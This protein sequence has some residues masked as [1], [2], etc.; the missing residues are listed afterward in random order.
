MSDFNV[1]ILADSISD[2]GNRIT[3]LQLH[4]WRPLLAEINTHRC[5]SRNA[6]S[7]R[8]Q[9]YEKRVEQV[10]VDTALPNH[11]N[12]EQPGMVGGIEFDDKTKK[13]INN[14]IQRL[15]ENIVDVLDIINRT[16]K[17]RTGY[18]IHKQYL[19]RY[20][21]PFTYT[22]Q[23]LTCTDW[24]NFFKLRLAEDAQPEF[25]DLAEEIYYQ[26]QESVPIH[27]DIH[28][29]YV[30]E[31]ERMNYSIDTCKK[32][33]V[34]RCARVSYRPYGGKYVIEKD[35]ELFTRLWN[36]GHYSPFEHIAEADSGRFFNLTGWRSFRYDLEEAD[37]MSA[38][39][40]R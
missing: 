31:E 1:K 40:S 11:W 27:T 23:V 15:A 28:L 26:L 3:T 39:S 32:I 25:K 10:L 33:S 19:N 5:M 12:A 34:A 37:R 9:S 38:G 2:E 20:L 13:F 4:Y 24:N 17:E 30:T 16:V 14:S 29:P 8:A 21:E 6:S 7:S 22:D 36:S 35:L 18:E